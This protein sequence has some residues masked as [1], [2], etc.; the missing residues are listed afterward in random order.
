MNTIHPVLKTV[1]D[2][3]THRSRAPRAAYLEQTREAEGRGPARGR[4]ACANLA[5]QFPR[6]PG[7]T[8]TL[9][10]AMTDTG[11]PHLA[12]CGNRLGEP[13]CRAL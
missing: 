12:R 2:R 10:D 11:L 4:L 7:S 9:L 1:T 6:L 8:P 5:A 3:I 13:N